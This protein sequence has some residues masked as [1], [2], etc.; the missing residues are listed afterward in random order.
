MKLDYTK[1]KGLIPAIVQDDTSKQ[2][3]MLG[4][5]NK[6][7]LEATMESGRVT[8]WSRSKK[9]LW[10]KGESSGNFLKVRS[11]SNDCDGDALLILAEPCGPTCHKGT[12][13][14]FTPFVLELFELIKARK[15]KRPKGSYTSSLFN[16]GLNKICE[17]VMEE[18]EE[19]TRAAKSETRQRLVEESCDLL[20]HAMVLLAAKNIKL[21]A[22]EKELLKRKS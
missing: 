3:L 7:A 9:R 22:I 13:S 10:Q 8:F 14:C 21:E 6:K 2:V 20:Y 12:R 19:V 18:A 16:D 15:A 11:I 5:M 1:M 4:Y 17:K